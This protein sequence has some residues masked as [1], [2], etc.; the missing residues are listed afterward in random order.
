MAD[1]YSIAIQQA[2]LAQARAEITRLKGLP[3]SQQCPLA[4]EVMEALVQDLDIEVHDK[5]LELLRVASPRHAWLRVPKAEIVRLRLTG[6]VSRY[7]YCSDTHYY[8]ETDC[9]MALY[10]TA[11]DREGRPVSGWDDLQVDRFPHVA[12]IK[13]LDE[14]P[15][16]VSMA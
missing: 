1:T 12:G 9:D 5:A 15:G 11:R 4:L 8:L 2:R 13:R 7:S 10:L 14:L 6:R 3:L 16:Y